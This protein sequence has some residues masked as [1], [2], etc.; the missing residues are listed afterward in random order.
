MRKRKS[1]SRRKG[2]YR[3]HQEDVGS[4]NRWTSA[5]LHGEKGATTCS[6]KRL[7]NIS[8]F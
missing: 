3:F 1:P 6:V 4:E 7:G 8:V 5:A 2:R